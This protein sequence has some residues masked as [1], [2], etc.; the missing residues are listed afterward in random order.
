[1]ILNLTQ[2]A[3]TPEQRE[4]GVIDLPA[5]QRADL[6]EAL[7]FV[8]LPSAVEISER[9]A[10]ITELAC[11]NGLGCDDSDDPHPTAAMIGGAGYLMPALER[12]LTGYGIQPVHAFSQRVSVEAAQPDGTVV[13]TNVFRHVG[14]VRTGL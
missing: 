2:H 13:K 5:G 14:W 12:A 11:A 7:T 10:F 6:V 8:S 4:A 9:A 1:M 3:A